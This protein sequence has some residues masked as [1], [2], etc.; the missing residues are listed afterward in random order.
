MEFFKMLLSFFSSMY[1]MFILKNSN[2]VKTASQIVVPA[3]RE[4]YS[5]TLTHKYG[6]P[7]PSAACITPNSGPSVGSSYTTDKWSDVITSTSSPN[8]WS[9][10]TY[11]LVSAS[12]YGSQSGTGG[13]DFVDQTA[14]IYFPIGITTTTVGISV[15]V[16]F[17]VSNTSPTFGTI[18]AI[19]SDDQCDITSV[20]PCPKPIGYQLFVGTSG[21]NNLISIF[22][23]KSLQSPMQIASTNVP[24]SATSFHF[25][26][27]VSNNQQAILYINGFPQIVTP[28]AVMVPNPY[29]LESV[30]VGYSGQSF[31]GSVTGVNFW[32]GAM[33]ATDALQSFTNGWGSTTDLTPT[34]QPTMTPTNAPFLPPPTVQTS[35]WYTNHLQ[36]DLV[37]Y[38]LCQ[39]DNGVSCNQVMQTAIAQ[40]I[41]GNVKSNNVKVEFQLF[42]VSPTLIPTIAPT[43]SLAPSFT[44]TGIP[45]I[46]FQPTRVP[47]SA[48]TRTPSKVPTSTPTRAPTGST[49]NTPTIT[50]TRVPTIT[51][52]NLGRR[53][54][55]T[56]V[57]LFVKFTATEPNYVSAG[58]GTLSDATTGMSNKINLAV[59]LLQLNTYIATAAQSAQ[60]WAMQHAVAETLPII[61]PATYGLCQTT[62]AKCQF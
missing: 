28:F 18:L 47:T 59:I 55:F 33:S 40:A 30:S 35:L 43:I 14:E 58:Y 6:V 37:N 46:S 54:Q 15:E 16:W 31:I 50:P 3:S 13:I 7:C 56:T 27:S 61:S 45:T 12:S 25:V 5:A 26:L 41:G 48:P 60:T 23:R 38:A 24:L 36:V 29:A 9:A 4:L 44:P 42:S 62:P 19:A 10:T 39:V 49:T 57:S 51:P 17:T 22:Y 34:A 8:T 53:L 2:V 20:Q 11:G 32:S 21:P 1:T 52:T